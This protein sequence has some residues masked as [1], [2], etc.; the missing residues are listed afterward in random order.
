[1]SL[2]K[3]K[4]Q[5]GIAGKIGV[6]KSKFYE[7]E[8]DTAKTMEK[9]F[10]NA[11]KIFVQEFE[12]SEIAKGEKLAAEATPIY[13]EIEIPNN[14]GGTKKVQYVSGYN[15][16]L[17][18]NSSYA[19]DKFDEEIAEQY[20]NAAVSDINRVIEDQRAFAVENNR[21]ISAAISSTN[22]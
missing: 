2:V 11:Q 1:M 6:A 17:A 7:S 18:F 19:A 22:Q 3:G 15:R 10:N 8:I 20:V 4:R 5:I 21:V 14:A 9:L 12:K 16:P 13:S